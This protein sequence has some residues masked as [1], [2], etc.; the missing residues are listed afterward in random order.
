MLYVQIPR[1]LK[2]LVT[3]Q[4]LMDN[5]EYHRSLL[6]VKWHL[7]RVKRSGFLFFREEVSLFPLDEPFAMWYALDRGEQFLTDA[8]PV[9]REAF[10]VY[11]NPSVQRSYLARHFEAYHQKDPAFEELDTFTSKYM[12]ADFVWYYRPV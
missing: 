6:A 2:M 11:R 4:E 8:F 7:L 10:R 1:E 5:D 3:L 12:A 9:H